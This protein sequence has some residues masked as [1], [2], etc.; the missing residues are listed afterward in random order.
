MSYISPASEF[1]NIT[2]TMATITNIQAVIKVITDIEV[3]K[4]IVLT[5]LTYTMQIMQ[6]AINVVT[7]VVDITDT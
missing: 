2:I 4:D 1:R 7:D 3:I 6:S 5:D